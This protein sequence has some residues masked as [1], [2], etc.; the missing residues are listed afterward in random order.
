METH[1]FSATGPTRAATRCFISSAA[2]LVKVMARI[3]NG[4]TP[5]SRMRWAM[6]WVSTRVLPEPAPATI[7][8]GP[9]VWV[10]ASY[11]TGL[12]PSRRSSSP[13]SAPYRRPTTLPEGRPDRPAGSARVGVAGVA[14]AV[15]VGADGRIGHCGDAVAAAD[16]VDELPSPRGSMQSRLDPS[17]HGLPGT[18]VGIG[19]LVEV[20]AAVVGD[21][22]G[23]VDAV[24]V[25]DGR[26]S[27]SSRRAARS[28]ADAVDVAPSSPSLHP[29]TGEAGRRRRN[30][31]ATRA[32][33]RGTDIDATQRRAGGCG[34]GRAPGRAR[35]GWDGRARRPAPR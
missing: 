9:S 11:W 15:E 29:T 2:L 24:V 22:V 6:R 32:L 12:R 7:S 17:A 19:A 31:P 16:Q 13:I 30:R 3:S 27:D 26:W 23:G 33:D 34:T 28:S 25:G 5:R 14:V 8:S 21:V 18:V 20:G 10:T 4:E 1:I 35:R